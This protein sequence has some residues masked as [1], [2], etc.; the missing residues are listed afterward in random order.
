MAEVFILG[1]LPTLS[2]KSLIAKESETQVWVYFTF[3]TFEFVGPEY[4]P[5]II[6]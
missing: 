6:F 5:N 3:S 2:E 4:N 1:W